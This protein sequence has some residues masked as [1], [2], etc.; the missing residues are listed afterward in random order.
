MIV[1]SRG[2]DTGPVPAIRGGG[3]VHCWGRRHW[4]RAGNPGSH[5]GRRPAL[6]QSRG[7]IA[8]PRSASTA[9]APAEYARGCCSAASPGVGPVCMWHC[10]R[11][12]LSAYVQ[13]VGVRRPSR[14]AHCPRALRGPRF[15]SEIRERGGS[16][17]RGSAGGCRRPAGHYRPMARIAPA[18]A[19]APS[20]PPTPCPRASSASCSARPPQPHLLPERPTPPCAARRAQASPAGRG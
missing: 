12:L 2:M 4:R 14:A 11:S 9:L 10:V 17:A 15:R 3:C 7:P 13:R 19:G 18:A 20:P 5:A 6:V 16:V 1:G 8:G